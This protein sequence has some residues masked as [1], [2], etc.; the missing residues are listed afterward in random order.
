MSES[1]VHLTRVA[2]TRWRLAVLLTSAM[3]TIYV[4]FILVYVQA[5]LIGRW[6]RKY[7]ERRLVFIALATLALGLIM[8]SVTPNQPHP[9][10][11]ERRAAATLKEMLPTAADS[12]IGEIPISLPADS[13]RGFTGLGWFLVALIP[14]A[15]GAGLIRP[16]LNSLMVQRAHAGETGAVLGVSAAFVSLADAVAPLIGGWIFQMYGSSAPFAI[17]GVIMAVLWLAS[18]LLLRP[19]PVAAG[20]PM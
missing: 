2:A 7:G 1:Q 19:Q 8:L 11:V 15:V 17:G 16:A 5:R 3:T 14:L 6:S 10:Y 18:L 20:Q 4:G 12:I 9:L 13:Q